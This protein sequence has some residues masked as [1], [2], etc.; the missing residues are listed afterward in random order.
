MRKC[1]SSLWKSR[2][3]PL[4]ARAPARDQIHLTVQISSLLLSLR[5]FTLEFRVV[6]VRKQQIVPPSQKE[7]AL[8][9]EQT[10]DLS[11]RLHTAVLLI[12]AIRL[13]AE[14]SHPVTRRLN[15]QSNTDPAAFDLEHCRHRSVE[16]HFQ[17]S[18]QPEL[19]QITAQRWQSHFASS[20]GR[21]TRLTSLGDELNVVRAGMTIA[22]QYGV[23]AGHSH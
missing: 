3:Y 19:F 12:S 17:I 15:T 1:L 9:Q 2:R 5:P 13:T 10:E 4:S 14:P 18:P 20:L 6:L 22:S 7:A 23:T 11:V 16:A 8:Q 21:A